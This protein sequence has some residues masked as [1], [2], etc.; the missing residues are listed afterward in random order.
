MSEQFIYCTVY[1]HG[2]ILIF[3]RNIGFAGRVDQVGGDIYWHRTWGGGEL[4]ILADCTGHGVSGAF[5][6]L[7]AGG[8]SVTGEAIHF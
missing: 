2:P 7:I 6:T 3:S 8:A 5:M 1:V 4:I